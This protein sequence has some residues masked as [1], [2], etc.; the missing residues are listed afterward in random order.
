[1]VEKQVV[2]H[3]GRFVVRDEEGDEEVRLLKPVE[4]SGQLHNRPLTAHAEP[5]LQ[6]KYPA[7]P[8]ISLSPGPD[9]LSPMDRRLSQ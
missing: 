5:V 4:T 6:V 1:M 2:I 9:P 8:Q 3:T 7:L